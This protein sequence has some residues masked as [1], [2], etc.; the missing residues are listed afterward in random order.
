MQ[1]R[2]Q[3]AAIASWR[4]FVHFDRQRQHKEERQHG[5]CRRAA[6]MLRKSATAVAWRQWGLVV[7]EAKKEEDYATLVTKRLSRL[8]LTLSKTEQGRGFRTW[9]I[10]LEQHRGNRRLLSRTMQTAATTWKAHAENMRALT[11]RLRRGNKDLARLLLDANSRQSRRAWRQW[12]LVGDDRARIEAVVARM[13]SRQR[14]AQPAHERPAELQVDQAG[15]RDRGSAEYRDAD[16]RRRRTRRQ[17][18]QRRRQRKTRRKSEL[19]QAASGWALSLSW[20]LGLALS[21]RW[22]AAGQAPLPSCQ[23]RRGRRFCSAAAAPCKTG[24]SG[25]PPPQTSPPPEIQKCENLWDD[26]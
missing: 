26:V 10:W 22:I 12:R 14:T 17:R 18:D 24:H 15:A 7:R 6:L 8:G 16:G 19:E 1:R 23:R 9:R 13:R 4:T 11:E 25:G 21:C 20:A 5:V 3:S 2:D